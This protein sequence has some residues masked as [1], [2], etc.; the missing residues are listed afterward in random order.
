MRNA[1]LDEA[2][3]GIKGSPRIFILIGMLR[4]FLPTLKFEKHSSR[5]VAPI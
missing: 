1:E 3:A 5:I 4:W 2:Q